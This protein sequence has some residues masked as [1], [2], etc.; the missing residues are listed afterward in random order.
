MTLITNLILIS[1]TEESAHYA[2]SPG[3]DQYPLLGTVSVHKWAL[4]QPAP[5]AVRITLEPYEVTQPSVSHPPADAVHRTCADEALL[6]EE[7]K[8]TIVKNRLARI[9]QPPEWLEQYLGR[10]GTV[11]W[12]TAGGAMVKLDDEATWFP[13]A[14]LRVED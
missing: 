10:T 1:E 2:E 3:K 6:R 14:E 11:L 4:P 5:T 8:V 9:N 7:A 13:Y 12:T